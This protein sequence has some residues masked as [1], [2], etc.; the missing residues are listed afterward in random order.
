MTEIQKMKKYDLSI[1]RLI[2]TITNMTVEERDL[3]LKEMETFSKKIKFRATRK[4]CNLPI[5]FIDSRGEYSAWVENVSFTGAFVRC[6]IPVLIDEQII[7]CF[8]Q[9][10]SA[11]NLKL[12]ARIIHAKRQGF[13]VQF[14]NLESRATRFLQSCMN[15]IKIQG[16]DA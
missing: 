4:K 3:V 11:K 14:Y 15:E 8:Q 7:M 16:N 13:G 6:R 2:N 9:K 12:R 1:L 10:D 5:K